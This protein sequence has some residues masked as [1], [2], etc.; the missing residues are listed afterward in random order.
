MLGK[1]MAAA[2]LAAAAMTLAPAPVPMRA[3]HAACEPGDKIDASTADQARKKIEAKGYRKVRDLKK[4]CDNVWHGTAEKDGA[5]VGIALT[6]D[7]QVYP[8]HD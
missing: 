7:G 8:E 2:L 1:T 5:P 4:G 6:P 3:A